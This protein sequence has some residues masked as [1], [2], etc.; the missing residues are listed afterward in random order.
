MLKILKYGTENTV[1]KH[2][3]KAKTNNKQNSACA[4]NLDQTFS[5]C[6]RMLLQLTCVFITVQ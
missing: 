1:K 5:Q 3:N 4:K 2:K 6:S